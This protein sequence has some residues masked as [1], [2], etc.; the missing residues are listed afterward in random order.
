M[1]TFW[2]QRSNITDAEKP[3]H[4]LC[5]RTV[6]QNMDEKDAYQLYSGYSCE[7]QEG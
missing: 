7:G 1:D 6:F 4:V 3:Y 2:K 5:I